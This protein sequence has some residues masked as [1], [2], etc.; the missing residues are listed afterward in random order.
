MNDFILDGYLN[1]LL[2]LLERG[3]TQE[4]IKLLRLEQEK[5]QE[6]YLATAVAQPRR[7]LNDEQAEQNWL[8]NE[9]YGK[10]QALPT[11]KQFLSL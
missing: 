8:N 4:V 5:E 1:T 11:S 6:N 9:L 10:E 7:T 3:Q 2:L